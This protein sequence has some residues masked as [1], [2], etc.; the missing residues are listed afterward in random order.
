[1]KDKED[2][3]INVFGCSRCKKLAGDLR[4][5]Y[6]TKTVQ[7]YEQCPICSGDLDYFWL[8]LTW[9]KFQESRPVSL[10]RANELADIIGKGLFVEKE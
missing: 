2:I 5:E 1:M 9:M 3:L 6:V 8:N 7:G 4:A 10:E